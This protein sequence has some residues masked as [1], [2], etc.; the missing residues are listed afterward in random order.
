MDFTMVADNFSKSRNN[1]VDAL[2]AILI[3]S[4]MFFHYFVYWA[5]PYTATDHY[6]Y[7]HTYPH[8][9][10]IGSL[11]V[12]VF[13]AVSGYVITMTLERSRDLSDFLFR[14]FAR[15]FP[16]YF[17]CSLLT[18][19]F[20]K[21]SNSDLYAITFFDWLASLTV[22]ADRIGFKFVDGSYWSL[23]VEVR[24]YIW[25][26]IF[27]FLLKS[28]FWI[29][30]VFFGLLAVVQDMFSLHFTNFWL[31]G[32]YIAFLLLGMSFRYFEEGNK[33]AGTCTFAVGLL[34]Y[35]LRA[36]G[37]AIA[38][39]HV[40]WANL[41]V[42]ALLS[43]LFVATNTK[44]FDKVNFGVLSYLGRLSYCFYLLHQAIG[45]T[46]IERI[47]RTLLLPELLVVTVAAMFTLLLA[48][49]IYHGV[50]E[51]ARRMLTRHGHRNQRLAQANL[52]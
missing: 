8:W 47:N 6:H 37:L 27:F 48:A 16:A 7:Q 29:G 42:L 50:E 13:F 25:V 5:P 35:V 12:H 1:A 51:P 3:L 21:V 22:H 46:I 19:A 38:G 39:Q 49:A 52:P 44:L 24:F 18:F 17:C 32:A 11:G 41:Y 43:G 10:G 9:I 28:R 2:R 34:L 4:V 26:A 20:L 15:L 45:V 33:L 40:L 30:M 14:R 23:G 31:L 36:P